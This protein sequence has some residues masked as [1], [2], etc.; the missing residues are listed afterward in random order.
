MRV[1]CI[2]ALDSTAN[3][4]GIAMQQDKTLSNELIAL[5]KQYWDAIKEQDSSAAT[6]LS[7]DP[8]VVVGAQGVGQIDKKTLAGMIQGANYKLNEYEVD[9][10]SIKV[11]P[12]ADDVVVVAYKVREEIEVDGDDITLEA[13]DSSVWVRRGGKWVCALHT[14]SPAG[15]PYG[16]H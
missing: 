11:R 13:F 9:E 6:K 7:D 4:G 16:R 15:D 2:R 3:P 5:E 1:A 12:V 10:K 8:C 14:E